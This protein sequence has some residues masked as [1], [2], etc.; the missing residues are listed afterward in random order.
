MPLGFAVAVLTA[1]VARSAAPGAL[2]LLVGCLLVGV[3]ALDTALVIVSRTRRGISVLTGGRDHLTHR[4]RM[5]M[6]TPGRVALVLGTAQ[7]VVSAAV[8]V[9]SQAG[10]PELVYIVLA[11][12]ILAVTAIVA[13]EDAVPME[14]S[15]AQPAVGAVADQPGRS[16]WRRHV[17]TVLLA[18]VG[19]GAGL[20]PLF[21]A[22]YSPSVW[23]PVGLVLMVLAAMGTIARPRRI[24]WPAALLVGGLSGL[25][26]WSL[27][28]MVWAQAVEQASLGANLWLSY[29]ALALLIVI[30]M[31]G[32][33]DA[34]VLLGFAGLGIAVV[35]VSVLVRLLGSDP[36]TLFILGR[37]NSPLGYINGEGCVFAMGVWLGLALAERRE[38][39]LAAL[40]MLASVVM[41]GL[42]LLSQSR[43]AAIATGVALL[44][45][46]AVIPG[47]RRRIIAV[48]VLVAAFAA[49]AGGLDHVYSLGQL[50]PVPAAAAHHA[51]RG[52]VLAAL[53]AALVW[54]AVVA[55]VNATRRRGA[56]P[57]RLAERVATVLAVAVIVVPVAVAIARAPRLERT[58]RQQWH[59]FV[60][61]GAAEG[62]TSTSQTRLFSGAGNR[63]DYWRVAW[64]VFTGQP[65][66]GVGAGNYAPYYFRER[67]TQESIENPHSLELQT[68][69]ELG[70]VGLLLLLAAV[71]GVAL[72]VARIAPQARTSPGARGLL[73]A[74]TGVT[75]VWFVDA[76][77]DWMQ[78][79]PGVTAIAVC[80]MS[81]VTMAARGQ[82]E[83]ARLGA[84][85]RPQRLPAL[86]GSAAIIFV[87]AI[88]GASLLRDGLARHYV[89]SAR[90]SLPSDPAAAIA[91]SNRSLGLDPANLDAYYVKAAGQARFNRAALARETLLQ[92]VQQDPGDFITWTLLGDL[93]VRAGDVQ[94]ARGYYRRAL[95]LDPREP[96]LRRLITEPV[97]RLLQSAH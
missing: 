78:L 58:A 57:A 1:N 62:G 87:L 77:G 13:L 48:A 49:A 72:G 42:V 4:T 47:R 26:L 36:G 65:A 67:R 53:A 51:V 14:R 52:L 82:P 6:K 93:E 9:A 92:A 21:S 23:M 27:L 24:P 35:G 50:G 61:L 7:A 91:D 74:G 38:P 84:G 5:R 20:S 16:P 3:P 96:A 59:A 79:L 94:A 40:G 45:A 41:A 71:G 56:G 28:S 34:A 11:F 89:N 33:R 75:V 80:A 76:S 25:G 37:L 60:H 44:I 43:G 70:V 19:L 31:N 29:A 22:Y 68:L 17:P 32:R 81:A 55:A 90:A 64:H 88:G 69:S 86:L 30:L 2:S 97:N 12:V 73:V 18:V 15:G 66:I 85:V 54:G 95:R 8:I 10:S 39:P 83:R 46:F 63:Y